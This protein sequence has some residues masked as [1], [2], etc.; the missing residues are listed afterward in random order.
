MGMLWW[1]STCFQQ[2]KT[3]VLGLQPAEAMIDHREEEHAS[4]LCSGA[5]NSAFA[6]N[7]Q[8]N[9][10]LLFLIPRLIRYLWQVGF[11]PHA[12]HK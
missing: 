4:R 2:L 9:L 8:K 10:H 6:V 7:S 1:W 5:G 12:L 3:S 11:V